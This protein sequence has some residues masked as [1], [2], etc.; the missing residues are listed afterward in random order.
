[1]ENA[2]IKSFLLAAVLLFNTSAW[3][4]YGAPKVALVLSGGGA[5]GLAEIPLLEALEEEGI[6]PDI[7][8]GTS[9]GALIGSLYCAGYS[10]KQIRTIMTEIDFIEILNERPATLLKLSPQPFKNRRDSYFDIAFNRS[11]IG[12]APG[13]IGDQNILL[14]L[15][16]YLSKVMAVDDFDKLDKSLRAVAT[17]VATGQPI[18]Y[19]SGSILSAVRASISLPAIFTPARNSDGTYAMDGGLV[20]NIPIKL[21]KEMGADVIIAMD[22]MGSV[23]NDPA[24]LRDL[25][26]VVVQIFN[27]VI[28]SNSIDQYKFADIVLKPELNEFSMLEFYHAKKIIQAGEKCVE[29]NRGAIKEI[30]A[31]I[32]AA[33]VQLSYPDPDRKSV[34]DNLPYP[35]IRKVSVRDISVFEPGP[36]PSAQEFHDLEGQMLDEAKRK[37]LDSRLNDFRDLYHFSS[38][39]YELVANKDGSCDMNIYAN[40]YGR[41]LSKIYAGGSSSMCIAKRDGSEEFL[42]NPVFDFGISLVRPFEMR[43]EMTVGEAIGINYSATPKLTDVGK[44]KLKLDLRAGV[45]IG[46][47]EP[48]TNALNRDRTVDDDRGINVS[49]G[50]KSSYL[51]MIS[52]R[53]GIAYEMDRLRAGYRIFNMLNFYAD[54]VYNTLDDDI[55]GFSGFRAEGILKVGEYQSGTPIFAVQA[56]LSHRIPLIKDKL[57]FGY[58]AMAG[59]INFPY[60]LNCGYAEFG[61][62]NGMCGYSYGTL[63]REFFMTGIAFEQEL[64]SAGGFPVVGLLH[65]RAGICD[66][67]NPFTETEPPTDVFYKEDRGWTNSQSCFGIG[68]Y[69]ALKTGSANLI[70]G[71]SMNTQGK[72]CLMVGFM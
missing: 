25:S 46:S 64:F 38:L 3:S 30:A 36:V 7:V 2:R 9:M 11:G 61:G 40:H 13:L 69:L 35:V 6:K 60:E 68:A 26:S 39:Y 32:K 63:R 31:K 22:V 48:K 51:D 53:T 21:A 66:A 5:K 19:G 27:L 65:A 50:I 56:S 57:S 71:C 14:E 37:I 17:N 23:H 12:S 34:Y 67:Y 33:G 4:A 47:L 43:A 55:T 45:K 42:V 16:G 18:V 1:M 52:L 24:S 49:C 15:A 58:D 54:A 70:V 8:L 44:M 41:D 29:Q 62:I 28:S 72:W 59:W 20:D 10:P